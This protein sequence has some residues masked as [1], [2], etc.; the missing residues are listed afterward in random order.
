MKQRPSIADKRKASEK[1][2]DQRVQCFRHSDISAGM[3]VYSLDADR[4][5][6][7][8]EVLESVNEANKSVPVIVEGRRDAEALRRLGFSG[9]LI[10]L[11]SGKS[12][13]EF[14]EDLAQQ[15]DR[16][17]LLLDWDEKGEKLFSSLAENLRGYWEE[18]SNF[19]EIIR[20][21][22]QKE[23]KDIEGIPGLLERLAG[24]EITITDQCP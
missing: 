5:N 23:I 20:A 14:C 11:H 6:R 22:C 16:V 1:L 18:F 3:N 17:I 24:T 12:I 7:L 21:L 9:D 4:A 10:T 15:Y 19:R 13:Y 2:Q 8:K